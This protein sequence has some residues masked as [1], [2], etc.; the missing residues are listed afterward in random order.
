M[1]ALKW[2]AY[3]SVIGAVSALFIGLWL[4]E[5]ASVLWYILVPV[6]C[7][8]FFRIAKATPVFSADLVVQDLKRSWKVLAALAAYNLVV[9]LVIAYAAHDLVRGEGISLSFMPG[10]VV[11]E[12]L[13]RATLIPVFEMLE[14]KLFDS[15]NHTRA[16]AASSFAFSVVHVR[17]FVGATLPIT[18]A[19]AAENMVFAFAAG[20][21]LGRVYSRSRNVPS[22][23]GIHWWINFQNRVLTYLVAGLFA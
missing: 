17:Q 8:C 4:S 9:A 20:M 19:V 10:N 3:A 21:F 6:L 15:L 11:E 1:R 7:L 14:R 5:S 16:I 22:V 23:I 18:R 12:L 13:F 2:A